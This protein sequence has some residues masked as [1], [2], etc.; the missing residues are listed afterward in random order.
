M[1]AYF[2]RVNVS[3]SPVLACCSA[4]RHTLR[5]SHR[6]LTTTVTQGDTPF[7]FKCTQSLFTRQKSTHT[8]SCL[9]GYAL[10]THTRSNACTHSF[11]LHTNE[12]FNDGPLG[13]L[14]L[15]FA[16]ATLCEGF[17]AGFMGSCSV[18]DVQ[19]RSYPMSKLPTL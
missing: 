16:C 9:D 18:L 15:H 17:V 2:N 4:H 8:T 13:L 10:S 14:A 5:H 11:R 6:T 1:G 7:S 3:F 19:D 12:H